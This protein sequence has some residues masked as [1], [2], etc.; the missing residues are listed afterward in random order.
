M[1]TETLQWRVGDAYNG[2]AGEHLY[3]VVGQRR[4]SITKFRASTRE[5]LWDVAIIEG[6]YR[7]ESADALL[8]LRDAKRWLTN[9]FMETR[10]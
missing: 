6:E 2:D 3:A 1:T 7:I 5:I 4:Y 10:Q 8:S 9:A